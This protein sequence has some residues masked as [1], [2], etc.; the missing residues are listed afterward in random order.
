LGG[1]GVAVGGVVVVIIVTIIRIEAARSLKCH[2]DVRLGFTAWNDDGE[3]LFIT[4]LLAAA[5]CHLRGLNLDVG[6]NPRRLVAF[7]IITT[8]GSE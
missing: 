1:A 4:D 6:I 8:K 3:A 2:R 7:I 5:P